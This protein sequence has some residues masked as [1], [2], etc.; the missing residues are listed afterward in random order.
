[1]KSFTQFSLYLSSNLTWKMHLRSLI[2]LPEPAGF[3]IFSPSNNIQVPNP[4]FFRVLLQRLGWCSKIHSLSSRQRPAQN[5]SSHQQSQPHQIAPTSFPSSFR[6]TSFHLL[7]ILSRAMFS[8]DQ[9]DYSCS[10]EACQ[11]HQKL[12]SFTPFPS[13]TA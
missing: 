8:G 13:F 2:S 7:Q 1:M 5:H 3:L 4:S 6:W 9:G 12:N 10:S 11:D